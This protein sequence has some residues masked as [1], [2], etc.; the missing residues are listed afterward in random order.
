MGADAKAL[1]LKKAERV[2]DSITFDGGIGTGPS[3][4]LWESS[5]NPSQTLEMITNCL[6]R[7][8]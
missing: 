8:R 7:G 6:S 4:S 2:L 1:L 5:E 3:I